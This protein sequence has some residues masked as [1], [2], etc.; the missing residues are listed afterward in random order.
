MVAQFFRCLL[1]FVTLC[2]VSHAQDKPV[3]FEQDVK[4]SDPLRAEQARELDAYILAMK[5]D[6]SR[7]KKL[8]AADYSS[9]AAFEKS[10]EPYRQ[11]FCD[12]IGYPPPGDAPKAAPG[13]EKMGEDGIGIYYR[14][15][16]PILPEVHAEG[17]YIVPVGLKGKAPLIVSMHGGGG[18]PE[19]ALFH[20]GANYHDMVRGAVKRGYVVFAPQH[21][22]SAEGFPKDVRN[23]TD[24]RL[25]L[26]GT[27]L[28]AVEIAK[29]SRSL[30]VIL[31]RPEVDASRVGMVGL[32][33]G[34]YYALV[35]PA[36]DTRIKVSVCSCYYGVQEAR[37]ERDELSI[38][39]DFKFKDRFT[40]FRD[41]DIAALICPRAL[42]IQ[43]G[44]KDGVDH[45]DGGKPLAPI[46]AGYYDQLK[47]SDRFQH[48][49]FEGGH[50]FH[51][52]SAWEFVKLHL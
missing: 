48:V 52:K 41:S 36:V 33:Y 22:F 32:S 26:V 12:S 11:A 35:T 25:R 42:Q 27:S 24:D 17:I 49:I 19:V 46:S 15:V 47:L 45:R 20:G 21:L 6:H 1:V 28:T 39:S 40:L 51:D 3:Y 34:G 38:P 37:Y 44:L 43:A 50:E 8:L 18:S 29:I 13:F 14:A 16:I 9:P 31:T 7:L 4:Q 5:C 10:V 30:D 23:R 2:V